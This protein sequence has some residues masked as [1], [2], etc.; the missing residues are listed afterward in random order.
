MDWHG[1]GSAAEN[2]NE[3]TL[4]GL[5]GFFGH[6]ALVFFR[7]D[8]SIG[9]AGGFDGR[10]VLHRCLAVKDLMSGDVH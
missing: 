9:H 2:S 6:V 4:E 10:L 1:R 5:D 7:G 8:K 3:V